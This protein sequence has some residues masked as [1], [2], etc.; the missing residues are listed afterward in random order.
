VPDTPVSIRSYQPRDYDACRQLWVEL[1][2]RHRLIYDDPA[3]GGDDPGSAFDAY[4][5]T[6]ARV[7][8]W[9]ADSAGRVVGLTGLFVH[10]EGGEVEP[11]VVAAHVRAQGIGRQL[12]ARAVQE[13]R[14]RDLESVSIR[15]VA[16]NVEAMA[17][18]HELGFRAVGHVD[19]FMDLHGRARRPGLELHGLPYEY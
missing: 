18:F 5:A 15:P 2:E 3:I 10:G 12:I 14:A 8:S 16:R 9:V 19:M 7:E 11:V 1:T 17:L 6:A 4:L 13:A